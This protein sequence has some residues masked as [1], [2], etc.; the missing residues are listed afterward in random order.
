M[1]RLDIASPRGGILDDNRTVKKKIAWKLVELL[2]RYF[3]CSRQ[4]TRAHDERGNHN[5]ALRL[6]VKMLIRRRRGI[7]SSSNLSNVS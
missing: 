1:P 7:C 3:K 5:R 6:S 4:S 2:P